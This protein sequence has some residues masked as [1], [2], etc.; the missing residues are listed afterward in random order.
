M[1][2]KLIVSA[3]LLLSPCIRAE[4]VEI[5]HLDD[6]RPYIVQQEDLVLFDIDD[7]LI[8]N[9]ISLGSPPWR[10][11]VKSK[12]PPYNLGFTLYD[13]LT[14][15]IAKNTSYR[16]VETSTVQLISDLQANGIP[17]FAFTA[18]GRSQWYTTDI[19]GVDQ[20]THEQL[21][22]VGID[23]SRT[24]IP[25]ELEDLEPTYFYK[26]II[27]AQH[28]KKGDLLKHLFKDLNFHPSCIIF[29]DD[30][31]DQVQSV[32]TAAQEAGIP[33]MGFWYRGAEFQATKFEPMLANLQ[34]ESLLL[35]NEILDDEKG[36]ELLRNAP[37][38]VDSTTYFHSIL[39]QMDLNGLAPS[40]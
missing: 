17:V 32:E 22:R 35:R 6:I 1:Y 7:T 27:F 29:V 36:Q 13:A 33:F 26:G 18:R 34:L 19:E 20:L 37:S 5:D 30:K 24:V 2:K 9:P 15:F 38:T 4:I 14:L 12:I 28:I 11:W 10:A 3:L 21:N 23:F 8:T 39:E 31:L 40:I 25:I 16:T